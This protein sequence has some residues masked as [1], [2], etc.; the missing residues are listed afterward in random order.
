MEDTDLASLREHK[1]AHAVKRII[2]QYGNN[3]LGYPL[4][5]AFFQ[6]AGYSSEGLDVSYDLCIALFFALYEFKNGKYVKKEFGESKPYSVLYRWKLPENRISLQDN[7][8][9]KAHFIP[10]YDIFRN[11]SVCDSVEESRASLKRYLKAIH[12]RK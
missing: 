3:A 6:Q 9:S 1:K 4:T 8:Y 2:S 5:Q 10:T 7:Y 11:F 12:W